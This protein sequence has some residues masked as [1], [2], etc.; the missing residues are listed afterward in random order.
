LPPRAWRI[1]ASVVAL[2]LG[3]CTDV[4]ARRATPEPGDEALTVTDASGRTVAFSDPPRRIVSLVP[5]VTEMIVA[6]GADDRLVGR[7]DFDALPAVRDI[8]S[9]GDG[10]QPDLERLLALEPDLVIR[11]EGPQDAVTGPA[12]DAR[13]IPHVGMRTDRIEDVRSILLQL[14]RLTRSDAR[15]GVLVA[16]LDAALDTVRARVAG[17]QR[18]RVAYLL[19]G[20]PPWAAGPDTYLGEL[21]EI[22]GARNVFDDLDRPYAPISIEEFLVRAPDAYVVAKGTAV[23]ERL[24]TRARVHEVSAGVETPG[25]GLG[26]AAREIARALHP[27]AFP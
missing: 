13:A 27:E 17:H 10:L 5:A 16:E 26:D 6:L 25:I 3:A 19:G 8:P 9:V 22:A 24:S 15:A 23:S 18:V 21:L 4:P 7:T 1:L 2:V 14:G 12:L 20:D 11:F